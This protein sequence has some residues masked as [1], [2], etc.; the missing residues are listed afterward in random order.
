MKPSLL[1]TSCAVGM[2]PLLQ[3]FLW[4]LLAAL[5]TAPPSTSAQTATVPEYE[6]GERMAAVEVDGVTLFRIAGVKAFPAKERARKMVERIKAAAA[7]STL[8]AESLRVVDA[9]DRSNILIGDRLLVT[10]VDKDAE[11]EGVPRQILAEI[12]QKK[13]L[14]AIKAY[15]QDRSPERL[16]Q[17]ALYTI[18]ATVLLIAALWWGRSVSRRIDVAMERRYKSNIHGLEL[19]SFEIVRAERIW[20]ALKGLVRWSWIILALSLAYLYLHFALGRL[21]WTRGL[22]RDLLGLV[23][24]P[25]R[26]MGTAFIDIIPNLVFIAILL[27]ITRYLLKVTRL[28]FA[29]VA[30]GNI[31]PQGFERDWAWPTYRIIR[32]LIIV[33]TLVVAYPYIPGSETDAFKG[34]SIFLG[35]LFSLGSSSVIANVIAGYTMT[36]RRAFRVGD[37]V[38]IGDHI[39]DVADT[40]LLVT[41][42]RTPKNE[43]IVVPNSVILG[44]EVINYSTLARQQGLILHTTVGIGYETSW[45]QV[46]AMLLAAARRAPGFLQEPPPFVL[47]KSLG[48]FAVTYEINVYCDRPSEMARLYTALHQNIL[49]VFN[50]YGVQIMTPAYEGDPQLPKVVPKEQWF[51]APATA[52]TP[53]LERAVD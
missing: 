27:I 35:V 53:Q 24:D 11:V 34:I 15:R 36:Y 6:A 23:V 22:A 1:S 32:L 40:R 2:A 29:G 41:H 8:S 48:D 39:G 20:G 7:D 51:T 4:A 33:F 31:T 30:E 47:Q 19:Q 37:R 12:Y 50:E 49:D 26:T 18:G 10:V 38:Q 44:S 28:Y 9:K 25:L 52:P 16:T 45:R 13:I 17:A 5:L 43:E 42:L 14:D 3:R 21:P 46:E